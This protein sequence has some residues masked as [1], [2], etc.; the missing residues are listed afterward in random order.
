[1]ILNNLV[2]LLRPLFVFLL[3]F[4]VWVVDTN[5]ATDS[6]KANEQIVFS[7]AKKGIVNKS[8]A[9]LRFGPGKD[10]KIC[11]RISDKGTS[12]KV[13]G[14]KDDWYQIK[15]GGTIAWIEARYLNIIEPEVSKDIVA[16]AGQVQVIKTLDNQ[17]KEIQDKIEQKAALELADLENENPKGD[18]DSTIIEE[19]ILDEKNIINKADSIE[20]Y[21]G[22]GKGF[23]NKDKV[24]LRF[25]P[26]LDRKICCRITDQGTTIRVLGKKDNWYQVKVGGTVAWIEAEHLTLGEKTI[27]TAVIVDK[28]EE[29]ELIKEREVSTHSEIEPQIELDTAKKG[30]LK[31][32]ISTKTEPPVVGIETFPKEIKGF[33]N[34]SK[35]VLRRG[36][37]NNEKI[38]C[39]ISDKGTKVKALGKKG[40]WYKIKF[41]S[42]VAWIKGSYLTLGIPPVARVEKPEP[43]VPV[44][45]AEEKDEKITA[46]EEKKQESEAVK[47]DMKIPEKEKTV[48]VASVDIGKKGPEIVSEEIVQV[49]EKQIPVKEEVLDK[50]PVIKPI[51]EVNPELKQKEVLKETV[52][53]KE[54][55]IVYTVNKDTVKKETYDDVI[56]TGPKAGIVNKEKAILRF[57]PGKDRK[58]CCRISGKGKLLKILGKK[59]DWYQIK[60]GGTIAWIE[61]ANLTIGEQVIAAIDKPELITKT[62]VEEKEVL[63]A[64][65]DKQEFTEKK[66]PVEEEVVIKELTVETVPM[67]E[68]DEITI[69][70]EVPVDV[71]EMKADEPVKEEKKEM[72][73]VIEKK[74]VLEK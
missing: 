37:G 74:E 26:G 11:C 27:A 15:L 5:A 30:D 49:N 21:T 71:S 44:S 70:E 2:R 29:K 10:R 60:L 34:R 35:V 73:A 68:K 38:C 23:L 22:P 53:I 46:I 45:I 48:E 63:I 59:G 6:E 12:L 19:D 69:K 40:E 43:V 65:E 51:K 1:M 3:I 32:V 61:A 67:E 39:R 25:G 36:P 47:V 66:E 28:V 16:A 4:N 62:K 42:A 14:K 18:A 50:T 31:P 58:L 24:T 41:G 57:G 52:K 72:I 9:I 7:K 54:P 20:I 56:Y 64:I 13:L 8:K 55:L 17:K 33:V